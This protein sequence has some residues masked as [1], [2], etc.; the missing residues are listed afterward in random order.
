MPEDADAPEAEFID[1]LIG[2]MIGRY[3]VERGIG[4][5]GMGS[6]Y[7]LLQPAI[8]KRMALKLLHEEYAERPEIVRRF[9]DEARA[10]NLI[11]HP[12]IVDITDFSHLPDGRPFI[13]M[14]H[15]DG[16]SLED[17]L[18]EQGPLSTELVIEILRQLCSALGAAHE[19]GIV[20][21]DLKPENIFLLRHPDGALHVKVLD[22]GIAKLRGSSDGEG[23]S[24]QTGIVLGTPT[25]MSPEQATGNTQSADHRT[26]IYSLGILIYQML[27]GDPPFRGK[28]FAELIIKH[29][30]QE[31][32]TMRTT[33]MEL[34]IAWDVLVT[35][36][37]AKAPDDRFQ[38][39]SAIYDA[40]LA[41]G[42]A[43]N[44]IAAPA[45]DLAS[46]VAA[47]GGGNRSKAW[48]ILV[49]LTCAGAAA[50]ALW[51]GGAFTSDSEE[52]SV[53]AGPILL[54]TQESVALPATDAMPA[55]ATRPDA[56]GYVDAAPSPPLP[57]VIKKVDA[58]EKEPRATGVGTLRISSDPWAS[59]YVD[60][61][62]RGQTPFVSEL[63]AGRHRI[64]LK[65]GSTGVIKNHRVL[66]KKGETES[67]SER[68]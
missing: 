9:F 30:Q 50:L 2:T 58:P 14:E 42:H 3:R 12:N 11:G 4:E 32:P 8:H 25:Y 21:R 24:T 10:V 57:E 61:K 5:G 38:S 44:P 26:D 31:A 7:E 67:I 64:R 63:P 47:L 29:I 37:M 33:R 16:Q 6:V 34:P 22:F 59:V 41:A 17:Y 19:K 23:M 48:W 13:V 62:F 39:M 52:D 28:S 20:H 36:A 53:S 66:L 51:L 40:A 55:A 1:P 18:L 56:A 35:K 43:L 49:P 27:V 45:E 54:D 68:W 15:L 65:N 60:G 46:D